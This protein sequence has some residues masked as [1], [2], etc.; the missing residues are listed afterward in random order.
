MPE[1][2]FCTQ[3]TSAMVDNES[4]NSTSLMFTNNPAKNWEKK[5]CHSKGFHT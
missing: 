3:E 5:K 1:T 4:W 2:N